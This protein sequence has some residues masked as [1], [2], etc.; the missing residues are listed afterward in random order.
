MDA[1]SYGTDYFSRHAGG[2]LAMMDKF[3]IYFGLKLS[4]FLFIIT[5]QLSITLPAKV[6]LWMTA[7]WLSLCVLEVR[8]G[9]EQTHCFIPFFEG[10]KEEASSSCD[11]PV[12]PRQ[13]QTPRMLDSG[14]S[15]HV[16]TSVEEYFRK[17]M[18]PLT[19]SRESLRDVSV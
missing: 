19:A 5:E 2:V 3:T 15:Q 14:S 17:D 6:S 1:A 16:F 10:V 8:N 9:T 12:L 7:L 4:F 13:R 11:S 18:R